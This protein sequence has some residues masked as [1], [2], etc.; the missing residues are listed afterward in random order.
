[1]RRLWIGTAI[2]LCLARCAAAVEAEGVTLVAD[3]VSNYVIVL[4]PAASPSEQWAAEELVSHVRQ[5]SGATLKVQQGPGRRAWLWSGGR[6][7]RRQAR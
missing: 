1:M 2:A 6:G 4:R 5:M 3:G 7:S